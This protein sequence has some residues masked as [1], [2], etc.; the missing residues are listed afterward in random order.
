M[1]GIYSASKRGY[2]DQHTIAS[3]GNAQYEEMAYSGAE[4]QLV[5]GYFGGEVNVGAGTVVTSAHT[6][7]KGLSVSSG[8]GFIFKSTGLTSNKTYRASVWTNSTDGRLYYKLNGGSEV[9]SSAPTALT[10]AGNWYRI[11]LLIPS[12]TSFSSIEVGVKSSTGTAIVFDDFRFQPLQ[13]A[14]T[15]YVYDPLTRNVTHVLDNDNMYTRYEYNGRGLL[16]R[17]YTESFKYGGERLVLEKRDDYK[18]FNSNP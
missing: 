4:D 18:R 2:L 1:N 17:T 9:V 10:K 8:Y 16:V 15:S 12:G 11:D 6:G 3:A 13:S 14:M 5:S 7:A